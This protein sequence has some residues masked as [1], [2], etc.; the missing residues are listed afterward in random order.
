V[1]EEEKDR[2]KKRN[3]DGVEKSDK[4]IRKKGRPRKNKEQIE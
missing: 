3:Q 4:V 2:G 1:G